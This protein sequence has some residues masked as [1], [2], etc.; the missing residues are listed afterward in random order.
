MVTNDQKERYK[1][2]VAQAGG[3]VDVLNEVYAG[4]VKQMAWMQLVSKLEGDKRDLI[5]DLIVIAE[6]VDMTAEVFDKTT[7]QVG[8]DV[9]LATEM[10]PID[11]IQEAFELR[12]SGRLN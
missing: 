2:I 3:N 8:A 6:I 4:A 7:E 1:E 11:D 12:Q 9:L 5:T 10:L